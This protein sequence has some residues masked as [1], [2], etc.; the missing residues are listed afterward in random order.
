MLASADQQISLTDPD[1]RSMATSGS[2]SG[3]VGYNV[4]VAFDTEHHLIE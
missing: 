1:S 3:V 2:G 4:L